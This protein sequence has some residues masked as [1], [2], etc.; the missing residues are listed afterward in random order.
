MKGGGAVI[1]QS[2]LEKLRPITEEEQALLRGGSIDRSLYMQTDGNV[3]EGKKL[4]ET[5]KLLA[6]RPHTRFVDFPEHTHDY[7][8]MV[9]MCQGQ[10]IHEINGDTVVLHTG[11]LLLIGQNTRQKIH[12]A[13]ETDIAVNFIIRPEFFGQTLTYLGS[14]ETPLRRFLIDC[15]C[16]GHG[17]YLH[18]QTTDV[19]PV[20]NLIENLLWTLICKTPYK[21]GLNQMTMGLLFLQLSNHTDRL[22]ADTEETAVVQALRYVEENY[23]SGSLGELASRMHY[24]VTWLSREIKK[25]TGKTYTEH[26]QQKRL[27]Q[28]AWMLKHTT[29]SVAEIARS[30]GY[31]N[32]SYFHRIFHSHFGCTPKYYRK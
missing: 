32:I 27:T 18:F 1:S 2:I 25:R 14:E 19:L 15:L 16:G 31:E 10:T 23:C 28:A 24:D 8:E 17:G 21:Q 20:Q 12:R 7:V 3:I 4:L 13:E 6:V 29:Y 11:E 30:V 22:K 26:V 5:G 9:Y